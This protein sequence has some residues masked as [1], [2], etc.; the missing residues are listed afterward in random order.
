MIADISKD[1]ARYKELRLVPTGAGAKLPQRHVPGEPWP[2]SARPTRSF[3]PV[4]ATH[5]LSSGVGG[6]MAANKS[7]L[8]WGT[9]RNLLMTWV[10]TLPVSI[11]LSGLLFWA[12]NTLA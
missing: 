3:P 4:S 5:V 2:P 1:L 8:Q 11:V 10:L 7:G 6:T 12:F 9:I